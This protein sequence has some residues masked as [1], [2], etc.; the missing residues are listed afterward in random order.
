VEA[1]QG[2]EA[3]QSGRADDTEPAGGGLDNVTGTPH[4]AGGTRDAFLNSPRLSAGHRER[5][6]RGERPLPIVYGIEP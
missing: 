1:G 4:L 6:L 2:L 3:V 5:L